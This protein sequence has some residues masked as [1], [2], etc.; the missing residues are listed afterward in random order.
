MRQMRK[1]SRQID[2]ESALEIFDKAPFVTVSM[3]REDGTPY[4]IPL[5]LVRTDER[6]FYFHSA[7]D[8]EKLDCIKTNPV[9]NLSAVTKCVPTVGPKDGSFTMQYRSAVALGRAEMVTNDEEKINALR[10]ICIRFLPKHMDAFDE[11]IDRSL[12]RTAVVRITL[13]ELPIGKHKEYD[14][15]GNPIKSM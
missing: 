1:S 9:V 5:S 6:T 11:S 4:G 15:D 2:T 14:K 12:H 7:L 3:T 13:T 8:G 10:A